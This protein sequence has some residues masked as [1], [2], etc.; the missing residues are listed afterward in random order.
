MVITGHECRR[1]LRT[2]LNGI[3]GAT[4]NELRALRQTIGLG[5]REFAAL[6]SIPLETF[7]PWDS[8]RRVVAAAVLQRARDAVAHHQRQQTLLPL[9]HWRKNSTSTSA[10][11]RRLSGPADSRHTSP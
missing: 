5:R 7:R 3:V 9:D 6:L 4:M 2:P 10:R 11:S 8:G 1:I